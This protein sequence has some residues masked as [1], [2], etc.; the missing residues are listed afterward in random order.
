MTEEGTPAP[1]PAPLADNDPVKLY[2]D[3]RTKWVH[4]DIVHGIEDLI[5][6]MKTAISKQG[7]LKGDVSRMGSMASAIAESNPMVVETMGRMR[8]LCALGEA[9]AEKLGIAAEDVMKRLPKP[10]APAAPPK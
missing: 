6:Q 3:E 8:Y 10:S 2:I 1:A 9:T 4:D 5:V 7:D